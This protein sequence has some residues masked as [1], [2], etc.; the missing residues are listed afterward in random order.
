MLSLARQ[1]QT[2][3]APWRVQ[4]FLRG[5]A[6]NHIGLCLGDAAARQQLAAGLHQLALDVGGGEDSRHSLQDARGGEGGV[7]LGSVPG[8]YKPKG[9]PQTKAVQQAAFG[10]VVQR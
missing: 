6:N 3:T 2:R 9:S 10:M 8:K 4:G 7:V 1:C 5:G